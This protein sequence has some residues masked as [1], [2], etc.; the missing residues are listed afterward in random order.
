MSVLDSSVDYSLRQWENDLRLK[1]IEWRSSKNWLVTSFDQKCRWISVTFPRFSMNFA[2]RPSFGA[3]S[4]DVS[5]TNNPIGCWQV[6]LATARQ[7][8]KTEF[9][10]WQLLERMSA[11]NSLH[12]INKLHR[13]R[14]NR[15]N[16]FHRLIFIWGCIFHQ[17]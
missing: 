1:T 13:T 7:C 9:E 8:E 14:D 12:Q 5:R 15:K 11:N 4:K 17:I 3:S 16:K 6:P 2:C 10:H